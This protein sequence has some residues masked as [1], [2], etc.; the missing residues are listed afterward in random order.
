[1]VWLPVPHIL[2]VAWDA[3]KLGVALKGY[4]RE[5]ALVKAKENQVVTYK[6]KAATKQI[7]K[8]FE[9]GKYEEF[10]R[11]YIPDLVMDKLLDLKDLWWSIWDIYWIFLLLRIFL[12]FNPYNTGYI[13]PD[14]YF[15]S[16]EVTAGDVFNINVHRTWEFNTTQPLRS[17]TVTYMV[18]GI[19]LTLVKIVNSLLYHYLGLNV[20]GPLL[21][22]L[23]PRVVL[24]LLSFCIDFMVYKICVLYK[25][26]FNQCL[27]TLSSSYIMLIYSTRSFSNTLELVLTSVLVYLVAHCMRR[28]D[29]TIYLQELVQDKYSQAQSIRERVDINKKRKKIPPHDYKYIIPIGVLCGIGI[30][31]RPTFVFYAFAPMFFWLQR[32]VASHSM[33]SPFQTFNF[34]IVLLTPIIV[35]TFIIMIFTDSLYYG[36]LTIKKLWNLNMT[37]SDWKVAPFN[38]IMYN[39]VPGNIISHGEHPRYTHVLVNLPL[40]LGPLAP[41]FVVRFLNWILDACYLP[42]MKKPAMRNVYALTLFTTVVPLICLSF[43]RHQEARFLI[44]VLPCI[45]LMCAHNLRFKVYGFKP[46]L[47]LWYIFNVI[48]MVWFG[49]VHQAG[50]MPVQKFIGRMTHDDNPPPYINLVYSHTY[51]PPRFPLFQPTEFDLDTFEGYITNNNTKYLVQDLGSVETSTLNTKLTDLVSRSQYIASK[52]GMPMQTYLIIPDFLLTQLEKEA[53]RSL[54]FQ[55]LYQTFPHV[56]VESFD[57]LQMEFH[58]IRGHLNLESV[59]T[60]TVN[61]LTAFSLNVVNVTLGASVNSVNI[62]SSQESR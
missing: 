40:L 11:L 56:S 37:Y 26:S 18:Y 58:D 28:S 29:E 57:K 60:G 36:D 45:V 35:T 12:V 30:F 4:K 25:H 23:L 42:W 54:S 2:K 5:R 19:P 32:G 14:E 15:Q 44:P 13:H 16:L 7:R 62:N 6:R 20:V 3:T 1:M 34:R 52:R 9:A 27:T 21:V 41:V 39:A 51:M 59:L 48:A 43:V 53:G 33:F 24:L 49:F 10:A 50:V 22:D 55:H 31:N 61:L 47:T 38:F 17:P 46:L 8:L